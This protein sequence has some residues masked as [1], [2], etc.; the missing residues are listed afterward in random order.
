MATKFLTNLNLVQNQILNGSF[1]VLAADPST[2]LFEGR[3]IYNST[4]KVIKVYTGTAWRKQIHAATS[5]TTALTINEANGT[6]TF[7]IADASGSVAGLLSAANFTLLTGATAANTASAIVRRDASGNFTASTITAGTVTGLSDPVNGTDAANKNYVDA[8]RSGLDVKQSVR[9][10]TTGPITLSNTQTIDGIAVVVGDRVLVKD[11]TTGSQNGI[12]VV[13]SGAWSRATDADGS[14]EVTSG[15]FTFVEEGTSNADSGWVLTTDG[16]IT[17]GTTSLVFAQFSGTGQIT[18]GDGLGK[19]G[20]TL[21]VNVDA[22]S[23]EIS[24]D[25]LRIASGA[26]GNGLGYSAGV[27]SVNVSSTGGLQIASD[28]VGIKLATNSALSLSASGLTVASSIAGTGLT[29]TNGVLS[30]NATNLATSGAGGVTGTLPVGNGGTGSTTLTSNGVLLGNGT[31]AVSA[32]AAGTANQVLRVPSAGGTP[33]FGSIDL[34]TTAAVGSSILA[35]G[36]G[37]TGASTAA[38]ARSALAVPTR[39]SANVPFGSTTATI[40]HSLGTTD[41]LVEV[42]E[43]STGETVYCDVTRTSTSA[44]TLGFSTAPELNQYRVVVIAI[45]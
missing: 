4:E 22:T 25:I 43:I 12:Y 45:A 6:L 1:E 40:T 24:S 13:A 29:W 34:S 20:N 26:A 16:T 7:A 8:A 32:T 23:I 17:V 21:F 44:V 30:A 42:F 37:G 27:L 9:V 2:N 28:E 11:Q 33:A 36:N 38:G 10:A 39:Y 14:A 5:S 3:L 15:L 18:A 19:T 41:V 31:S 35:V